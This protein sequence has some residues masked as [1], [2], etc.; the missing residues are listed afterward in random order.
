M[1]C[2]LLT[3]WRCLRLESLVNNNRFYF[4]N[5]EYIAPFN[6]WDFILFVLIF[7]IL[8]FLGW[9]GKQ[10]ATPYSLGEP[11]SI[12]LSPSMLPFYALRTVYAYLLL[13][14][15]PYCLLLW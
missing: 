13:Y 9:A 8:F 6:R 2:S 14:C 12:T 15:C 10:M 5:R 7:M 3:L 1:Q 11:L 4:V